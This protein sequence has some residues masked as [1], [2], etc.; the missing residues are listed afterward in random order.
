MKYLLNLI[1]KENGQVREQTD[2]SHLFTRVKPSSDRKTNDSFLDKW[3]ADR[4]KEYKKAYFPRKQGYLMLI[5]ADDTGTML[6][7]SNWN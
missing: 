7:C 3:L 5:L 4:T 1:N 6:G 2:I